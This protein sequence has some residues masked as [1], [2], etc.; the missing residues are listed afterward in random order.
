MN[1]AGKTYRVKPALRR[2]RYAVMVT[3]FSPTSQQQ[4]RE[5]FNFIKSIS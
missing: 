2:K 4:G 5:K 1:A 3:L